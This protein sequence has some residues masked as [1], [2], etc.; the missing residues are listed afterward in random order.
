MR[1]CSAKK[2]E[3]RSAHV[4]PCPFVQAHYTTLISPNVHKWFVLR[5]PPAFKK[6]RMLELS[7]RRVEEAEY[8][9]GKLPFWSGSCSS[10]A[11]DTNL[12]KGD[13]KH[14]PDYLVL[15]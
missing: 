3:Y 5:K 2:R 1:I 10:L 4:V 14:F 11:S 9:D 15:K 13:I 8:I 7:K 12:G 6:F